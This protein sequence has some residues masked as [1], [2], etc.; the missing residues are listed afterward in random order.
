MPALRP[1]RTLRPTVRLDN[2][3]RPIV[4]LVAGPIALKF[5]QHLDPGRH[6]RSRRFHS[7]QC[8]FMTGGGQSA[9]LSNCRWQAI[10]AGYFRPQY[11]HDFEFAPDTMRTERLPV[12]EV[13]LP[14]S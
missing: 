11:R 4:S 10:V 2:G 14:T 6:P 12:G 5:E 1:G 9:V 13:P 3:S 7:S 8:Q